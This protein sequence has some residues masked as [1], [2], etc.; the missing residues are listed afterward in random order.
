MKVSL[1]F[2]DVFFCWLAAWRSPYRG[3]PWQLNHF[4]VTTLNQQQH[5]GL[6]TNLPF[7]IQ[8]HKTEHILTL[9]G[10][11]HYFALK[12]SNYTLFTTEITFFL[13]LKFHFKILSTD[14]FKQHCQSHF[15]MFYLLPFSVTANIGALGLAA[16]RNSSSEAVALPKVIFIFCF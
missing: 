16:V 3:A 2:F 8:T 12:L 7:S 4:V 15:L 5:I 14:P 9:E 11:S 6:N 10:Y 1:E 13:N